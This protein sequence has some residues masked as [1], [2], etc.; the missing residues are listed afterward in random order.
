MVYIGSG[1]PIDAGAIRI[2]NSSSTPV[3]ID[4]VLVDL[5]RPGPTFNLWGSFTIP[6]HG[7]AILTQTTQYNFDTSDYWFQPCFVPAP[8][9]DPR[10]PKISI[11]IAGQTA[12]Y[13]DTGH[14]LDTFGYDSGLN[15]ASENESLQ[16]R[17]V[18]STPKPKPVSR[19]HNTSTIAARPLPL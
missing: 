10:I 13:L 7:S 18:G 14:I 12:S 9:S 1:L 17:P 19:P 3:T 11:T 16:W 8:A 15:C 6:P 5:Q 2:D 4:R